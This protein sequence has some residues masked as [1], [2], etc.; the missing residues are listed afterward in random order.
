MG[1]QL[2]SVVRDHNDGM[3]AVQFAYTCEPCDA[4]TAMIAERKT[5][6]VEWG[7]KASARAGMGKNEG[8]PSSESLENGAILIF[9]LEEM[10]FTWAL[11]EEFG[12][13]SPDCPYPPPEF[14]S[15]E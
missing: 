3:P 6:S 2:V 1:T 12:P 8:R 14:F 11:P 9:I 4:N 10:R 5:L 15:R 7:R 13:V